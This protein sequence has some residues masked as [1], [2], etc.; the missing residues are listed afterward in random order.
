M[1]LSFPSER[2]WEFEVVCLIQ[3]KWSLFIMRQTF[4]GWSSQVRGFRMCVCVCVCG[5]DH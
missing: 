2:N 5:R 4:I 3:G 1:S